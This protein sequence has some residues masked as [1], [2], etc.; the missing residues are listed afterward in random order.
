MPATLF[1]TLYRCPQALQRHIGKRTTDRRVSA[2][3][4]HAINGSE[5]EETMTWKTKRGLPRASLPCLPGK[6]KLPGEAVPEP[7]ARWDGCASVLPRKEPD[8]ACIQR[9]DK[10][11]FRGDR[12]DLPCIPLRGGGHRQFVQ[13]CVGREASDAILPTITVRPDRC[14]R[15]SLLQKTSASFI[16][17]PAVQR[18]GRP[19]RLRLLP[20][21]TLAKANWKSKSIKV[22]GLNNVLA[23]QIL[24]RG[25]GR[26]RAKKN[27]GRNGSGRP[28]RPAGR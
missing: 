2:R 24:A 8:T 7:G 10:H 9:G 16:S 3:G 19:W 23:N 25:D 21:L 13:A 18:T 15:D 5:G 17:G 6:N 20:D 1:T 11:H 14:D 4:L 28:W 12:F 27:P 22:L 26:H